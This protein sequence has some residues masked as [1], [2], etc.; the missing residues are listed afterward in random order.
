M[1]SAV[2]WGA[3][4]ARAATDRSPVTPQQRAK[5]SVRSVSPAGHDCWHSA[6]AATESSRIAAQSLTSSDSS[7]G[8]CQSAKKTD[9]SIDVLRR[10][11]SRSALRGRPYEYTSHGERLRQSTAINAVHEGAAASSRSSTSSSTTEPL[12]SSDVLSWTRL[13]HASEKSVQTALA[14]DSAMP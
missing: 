9:A 10:L 5:P 13:R 12:R 1:S 14:A 8:S 6:T 3:C 11:T 7:C 4:L 2:R